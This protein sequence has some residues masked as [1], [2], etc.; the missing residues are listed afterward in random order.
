M[1]LLELVTSVAAPRDRCFDLARS[2]DAHLRAA[3]GTGE[4]AV[5]G[6]LSGLL[7]LDEV[8]TWR[9]KHL[10]LSLTLSTR[11]TAFDRPSHFQDSMV[12]GPLARMVHD[13]YFADDGR[14]GTL[15]RDVFDF[16]APLG[17]L[18]RLAEAW[19]LTRHFRRFLEER[20]RELKAIAESEAWR[21]FLPESG[22]R[23]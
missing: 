8:V 1:A 20:N 2:V 6:R 17:P 19:W 12:R 16:L 21:Q 3:H 15:V 13:H 4:R 22:T 14:G 23:S 9:A 18:G 10:G 7:A 5:E 11:I